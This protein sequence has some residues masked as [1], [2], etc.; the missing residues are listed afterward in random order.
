MSKTAIIGKLGESIAE[1]F[2]IGKGYTILERNYR[3]FHG[4]IDIIAKDIDTTV[5][6]EVKTISKSGSSVTRETYRP[7]FNVDKNKVRVISRT[8]ELYMAEKSNDC[9]WR[10]DLV[11]V[12][13]DEMRSTSAVRHLKNIYY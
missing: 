13:L 9:E 4:E 6:V 5:F 11:A 10:I 7:E 2:L 1:R 8:A 12:E 3:R